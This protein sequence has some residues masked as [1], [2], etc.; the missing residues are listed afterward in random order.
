MEKKD[1][2]CELS[3]VKMPPTLSETEYVWL[4]EPIRGKVRDSYVKSGQRFLIATDRLSA[5]DRIITTVPGKGQVLTKMAQFWFEKTSHIVSNHM[6]TV[7]D[8]NVIVGHEVDIVPIE[9]VVRGYLAGSAWRDYA[10]GKSVSGVMLPSGL[11]EFDR[12][13][14]PV[15]TPSTKASAGDHDEP[16]SEEQ[17][18]QEELVDEN[19]WKYIR[20]KSLELFDYGSHEV[21]SRGLVLVDTKYE[22]GVHQGRVVLADEIH[23]LDS[24]RFWIDDSLQDRRSKGIA[25]EMLDKEPVRRWLAD[26]GFMGEG[27]VPVIDESYRARLM[28]HYRSCAEQII[29]EAITLEDSEPI[30]RIDTALKS[31]VFGE[32]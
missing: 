15:V 32:S 8:P 20:Q 13:P 26:K 4:G 24:S 25:P 9:V 22:F 29:G 6:I 21:A 23:T 19:V 1:E 2:V 27:D 7:L 10:E 28:E 3:R 17:I 5:F 31:Y 16:I 30:E 14:E 18:L 11:S 12:L